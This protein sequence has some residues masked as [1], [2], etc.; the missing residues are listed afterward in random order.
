MRAGGLTHRP[1]ATPALCVP[2]TAGSDPPSAHHRGSGRPSAPSSRQP[3]GCGEHRGPAC[4]ARAAALSSAQFCC[5]L[6]GTPG[7]HGEE[8]LQEKEQKQTETLAPLL[9][10]VTPGSGCA[11]NRSRAGRGKAAGGCCCLAVPWAHRSRRDR[12][13]W[14]DGSRWARDRA[15]A[16]GGGQERGHPAVSK[17]PRAR[18]GAASP[19]GLRSEHPAEHPPSP[20]GGL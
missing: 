10:A 9:P 18:C 6:R 8:G 1:T 3:P 4:P 7:P 17:E 2:I 20:A 12:R 5:V 15:T 14:P 11:C 13:G 19:R 16:T